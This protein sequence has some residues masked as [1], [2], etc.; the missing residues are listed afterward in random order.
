V[1]ILLSYG[2]HKNLTISEKSR[3]GY[4]ERFNIVNAL[5]SAGYGVYTIDFGS[6]QKIPLVHYI[7][8]KEAEEILQNI[9]D[10]VTKGIEGSGGTVSFARK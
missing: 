9:V 10:L 7:N 2:D 6:G 5:I 8:Y 1:N 4:T 3:S